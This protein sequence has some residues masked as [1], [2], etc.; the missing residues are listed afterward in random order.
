[1]LTKLL[2]GS[3]KKKIITASVVVIIFY[4]IHLRN[5][6]SS[7]DNIKLAR[8]VKEAG[9][10]NVDRL[11]WRRIKFLVK[12]VIPKWNCVEVLDLVLLTLFL[13]F[14]TFLSIYLADVNGM[15]VK[16]IIGMDFFKFINRVLTLAMIAVP[17]SFVNSYLEFTTKRL[18]INFKRRLTSYFHDSYLK[19]RVFYQLCNLDCRVNNP[20]QRLTADI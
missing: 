10:G 7:T 5:K 4:L 11:F 6:K 16:A 8:M 15:I 19:D 20:D 1:M 17:A 9:K 3:R 13:V 18:A 12:I 2:F 14:R